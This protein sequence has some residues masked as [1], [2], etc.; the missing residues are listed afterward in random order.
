MNISRKNFLERTVTATAAVL[1]APVLSHGRKVADGKIEVCVI[2]C[3]SVS[4]MYL[5]I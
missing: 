1:L 2:G 5:P 3:G 4:N